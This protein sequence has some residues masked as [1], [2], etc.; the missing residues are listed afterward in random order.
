[1]SRS[2]KLF[3][4]AVGSL[5]A[6]ALLMAAV[7]AALLPVKAKP[8]VESL[9][10]QA[11]DMEVHVGGRVALG[12][13]PNP[14]I[15]LADMHVRK[16][17]GEIASV[18]EV[19][20]GF[21]LLPLLHREVWIKSI[22]LKQ[23][24]LAIERDR[25]GK[26]NVVRTSRANGTFRAQ[27][28]ESVSVSD[29]TLL[30]ADEQSGQEIEAADCTLHVSHLRLPSGGSSDVLKNLSFAAKL[31][32]KQIGTRSFVASD[33]RLSVDG[34]D[35][36]FDFD[37]VTMRLFG[38]HGS[39]NLRAE[40]SGALP[41]Y[42]VRYGLTQFRIEEFFKPLSPQT[43]GEGAMDFSASLS[44]RGKTLDALKRSIAGEASLHGDN[45]TLATGD[46]DKKFARYE[47]SQSF[48][49][50]DVSA[51]FFAGPLALGVTKG[52]HFARIFEGSAGSTPIR[53]LVSHWQVEHGV[54]H[55]TDVA[56][57]T[58]ENRVA[59]KG[60]LDF[61]NG[62]FDEVTVALIDAKGCPRVQQRVR[63]PFSQPVVEK[64]SVLKALA[65]PTRKLLE[66]AKGLFGGECEVFYAG[67]VAPK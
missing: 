17:G 56:M 40:V 46:L 27:I 4:F 35:G 16:R 5:A 48:N 33:V 11:L 45:L 49:L 52:F 44:L 59:L 19:D 58:P 51:V 18:K 61:V 66:Q 21:E 57:A 15:T 50:V 34:K 25:E 39:G 6:L 64:P 53:T 43:V 38:G 31:A 9:A 62:R 2:A 24:R 60:A 67:S 30:Y 47:S 63:G 65:G 37:P 54:A 13:L 36:I 7:A 55:A 42:H 23:L 20:L 3:L 14:H 41:V 26:L 8:W 1:M 22:G 10:S 12:F 32:C 29:A 28:V